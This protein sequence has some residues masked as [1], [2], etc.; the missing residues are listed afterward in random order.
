[1]PTATETAFRIPGHWACESGG[2]LQ[3][4]GWHMDRLGVHLTTATKAAWRNVE[5]KMPFIN[6]ARPLTIHVLG[7]DSASPLLSNTGAVINVH[8]RG[9]DA[10]AHG[11]TI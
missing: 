2:M 6:Q 9:L 7:E 3:Y 5:A 4:L 11:R 1:M 10:C 8:T